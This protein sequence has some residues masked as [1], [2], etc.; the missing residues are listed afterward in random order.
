MSRGD[1][2]GKPRRDADGVIEVRS[3]RRSPVMAVSGVVVAASLVGTGWLALR[4]LDPAPRAPAPGPPIASGASASAQPTPLAARRGAGA[5]G[6]GA[7]AAS[8]RAAWTAAPAGSAA[9]P[10]APE[11]PPGRLP[12]PG[13]I[14]AGAAA[15]PGGLEPDPQQGAEAGGAPTG[16]AAFPPLGT[17]PILRGIVVPDGFELPPGYVRHYQATDDGRM[18]PP[19]LRFHPDQPP[20]DASG[21]PIAVPPGGVVPP[22]LAPPGL[23]IELLDVPEAAR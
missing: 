11:A 21:R 18:L 17:K 19:I 14:A 5:P 1:H 7:R 20:V 23:P 13:R 9:G 16:I 22:E 6:A 4:S 8:P 2:P 15:A 10:E 3:G 12:G